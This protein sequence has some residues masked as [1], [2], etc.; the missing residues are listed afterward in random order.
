[1]NDHGTVGLNTTIRAS[2]DVVVSQLD[3][4]LV[5]M[6]V[7]RGQYYSLDDIGRRV[8]ELLEKPLTVA[9]ICDT[10]VD[11]Y[12]VERDECEKDMLAWL[13]ELVDENLVQVVD[14]QGT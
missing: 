14:A 12:D 13:R 5:M 6:S 7:D 9:A 1:M 10:V 11:E 8:W 4:E 2:E 3:D